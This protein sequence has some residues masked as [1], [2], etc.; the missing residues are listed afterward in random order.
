VSSLDLLFWLL[1]ANFVVHV[2]DETLMNGGFVAK[3]QQHWWPEYNSLMF[4]WFNTGAMAASR[5]RTKGSIPPPPPTPGGLGA[6]TW[7]PRD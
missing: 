7:P 4:S 5:R 6:G 3:V 2:L 1:P